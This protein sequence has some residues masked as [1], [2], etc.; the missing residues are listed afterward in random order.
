MIDFV[1]PCAK[2]EQFGEFG[3]DTCAFSD[4]V[5]FLLHPGPVIECECAQTGLPR[6]DLLHLGCLGSS[7]EI[8]EQHGDIGVDLTTEGRALLTPQ[9]TWRAF[10]NENGR[11]RGLH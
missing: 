1:L 2:T 3:I 6:T 9:I 11:G 5:N 10:E 4:A 8:A 7:D